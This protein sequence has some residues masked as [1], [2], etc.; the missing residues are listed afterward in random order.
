[1][2]LLIFLLCL[3]LELI[4]S[5]TRLTTWT[6]PIVCASDWQ[7]DGATIAWDHRDGLRSFYLEIGDQTRS[8]ASFT[9]RRW[10]LTEPWPQ[11]GLITLTE[12]SGARR[13]GS[14]I[15]RL[16]WHRQYVPM[17]R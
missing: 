10:E 13:E 1:M 2:L 5:E 11:A 14:A 17:V 16:T 6:A 7:A 9:P 3:P 8:A 4:S 15:Y 12:Y